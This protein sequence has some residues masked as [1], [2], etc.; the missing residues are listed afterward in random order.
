[1]TPDKQ[2]K[3]AHWLKQ[4][5]SDDLALIGRLVWK[6]RQKDFARGDKKIL[7]NPEKRKI[8]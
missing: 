3:V 7:G 4:F 2:A 6:A 5:S 1:M 8:K